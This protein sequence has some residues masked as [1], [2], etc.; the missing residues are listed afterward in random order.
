MRV[1]KEIKH[2]YSRRVKAKGEGW[3]E[4]GDREKE[5]KKKM[6]EKGK[7]RTTVVECICY[8]LYFLSNLHP[9]PLIQLSFKLSFSFITY[10]LCH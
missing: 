10:F 4:V 9:K 2:M 5:G 3:E 6:K 7:E 8:N 1:T